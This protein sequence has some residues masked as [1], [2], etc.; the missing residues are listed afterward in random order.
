MARRCRCNTSKAKR[1]SLRGDTVSGEFAQTSR[2]TTPVVSLATTGPD[3]E[4]TGLR[5]AEEGR[6]SPTAG[7]RMRARAA[8]T[9]SRYFLRSTQTPTCAGAM[10]A[11]PGMRPATS[12]MKATAR[13]T[14]SQ[15]RSSNAAERQTNGASGSSQKWRKRVQDQR[16]PPTSRM[17]RKEVKDRLLSPRKVQRFGTWNVCT[18]CGNWKT[19][20]LVSEMQRYKLSILAV[21]ETHLTGKGEMPLDQYVILFSGRQDGQNMEGVGLALSPRARAGLHHHQSLSSRIMTAEFLSQVGPRMI[22]V[23]Y[24]PTNQDSNEEKD[25]FYEDLNCVVSRGNEKVMVMGD[26][27]ASVSDDKLHG[28]VGLYG[29]RSKASEMVKDWC[30][31]HVLTVCAFC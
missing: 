5:Q 23:V 30:H 16:Q 4:P 9:A 14:R 18:L 10:S 8:P 13:E 21:T 6:V 29:L 25:K 28:V 17:K 24:A 7:R 2:S 26:F 31:L 27:N 15:F 19:D 1:T 3:L 22:V 11:G 20:Q 12:S